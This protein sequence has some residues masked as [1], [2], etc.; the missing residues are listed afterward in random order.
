MSLTKPIPIDPEI[1]ALID[2][3]RKRGPMTPDEREAQRRS[4]V[5]GERAL[6]EK[7]KDTPIDVLFEQYD[8]HKD[9]YG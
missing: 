3:A 1:S 8:R 5:T 4:W 9:R 6:T 7:N 2:A